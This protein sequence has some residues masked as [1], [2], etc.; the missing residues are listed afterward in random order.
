[1][2]C[3]PIVRHSLTIGVHFLFTIPWL[4]LGQYIGGKTL[5]ESDGY[6]K[7]IQMLNVDEGNI[8]PAMQ[9]IPKKFILIAVPKELR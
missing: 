6:I 3:T 9:C 2:K 5:R 4:R 7:N 8:K 1:M